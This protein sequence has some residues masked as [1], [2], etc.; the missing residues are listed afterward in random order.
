MIRAAAAAY[1][2]PSLSL[3]DVLA[4]A[5]PPL[6]ADADLSWRSPL[7]NVDACGPAHTFVL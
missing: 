6:S 7:A 2:K 3:P 4:P 1:C 5:Q